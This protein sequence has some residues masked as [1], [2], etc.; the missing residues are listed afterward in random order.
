MVCFIDAELLSGESAKPHECINMPHI[1]LVV[2]YTLHIY[3]Y[4]VVVVEWL[5]W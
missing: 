3:T 1:A 5:R 2:S 4:G